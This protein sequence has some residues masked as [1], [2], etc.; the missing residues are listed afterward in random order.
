[1]EKKY[2]KSEA[3]KWLEQLDFESRENLFPG[4]K[5]IK[6]NK[7]TDE[8]EEGLILCVMAWILLR[9]W[10]VERIKGTSTLNA[11]I[12]G[13]GF[14]IQVL[15]DGELNQDQLKDKRSVEDARGYYFVARDF[16]GWVDFYLKFEKLWEIR[17]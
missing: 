3:V 13:V 12:K 14:K 10:H 11:I 15:M 5:P 9:G 2:K 7:Y 17:N 1:M 4:F 6:K 16:S 8:N